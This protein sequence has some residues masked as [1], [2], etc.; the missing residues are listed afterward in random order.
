MTHLFITLPI[1]VTPP[2]LL[3]AAIKPSA[4]TTMIKSLPGSQMKTL[5]NTAVSK[6]LPM[7]IP[8]PLNQA[9]IPHAAIKEKKV[10]YG[11]TPPGRLTP[12]APPAVPLTSAPIL[13]TPLMVGS[14]VK[15]PPNVNRAVMT[16]TPLIAA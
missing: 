11:G 16:T 12:P 4:P 15:M 14:A 13:T 3:N 9:P 1:P 7:A 10:T 8:G 5:T 2:K 6:P